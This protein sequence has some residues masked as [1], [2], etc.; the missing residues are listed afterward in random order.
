VRNTGG[1][2]R[3]LEKIQ[4]SSICPREHQCLAQTSTKLAGS[5]PSGNRKPCNSGGW[6]GLLETTKSNLLLTARLTANSTDRYQG[7]LVSMPT[8][9]SSWVSALELKSKVCSN[10][11]RRWLERG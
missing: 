9:D 8:S 11:K 7:A 3:E 6:Q 2:S 5:A 1:V 10:R 4:K